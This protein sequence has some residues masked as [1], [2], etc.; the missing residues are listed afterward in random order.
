MAKNVDFLNNNS[1]ANINNNF[2]RVKTALV[3]VI[4]RSGDLP[5]QMNADLDMNS[6]DIL[7][8]DTLQV[9]DITID[10]TDPTGILERALDAVLIA[11]GSAERAELEAAEA[12][13]AAD[14]AEAAAIAAEQSALEAANSASSIQGL[15]DSRAFAISSYHPITA[16]NSIRVSGYATAGDGGGALYKKV[17]SEPTHVGKMPILLDDAVTTVWYEI[18]EA[19]MRPEMFGVLGAGAAADTTIFRNAFAVALATGASEVDARSVLGTIEFTGDIFNGIHTLPITFRTGKLVI[20]MDFNGKN[21]KI[22]SFC[23]W[24]S[25]ET[26]IE[27]TVTLDSIGGQN[28][29]ACALIETFWDGVG[30]TGGGSTNQYTVSDATGIHVGTRLAILGAWRDFQFNFTIGSAI[31]SSTVN[32]PITGP[33]STVADTITPGLI[34]MRLDTAGNIEYVRGLL[35]AG[36][37]DT[38]V[39]GGGRGQLGSTAISHSSGVA[40]LLMQSDVHVVTAI[41]GNVLTLAANL[42][43]AHTNSQ[44]RFGTVDSKLIGD[45]EIDGMYDRAVPPTNVWSCLGSTLS[46]RFEAVGDIR[47]LRAPT[48]GYFMLGT[49]D[50]HLDIS[51]IEKCGRPLTG[52]GG[53]GWLYGY[54]FGSNVHVKT[55]R[56]GYIASVID[57]K[58]SGIIFLGLDRPNEDFYVNY[59]YV[60]THSIGVDVTASFNGY[61]RIGYSDCSDS[62][63]GIFDGTPQQPGPITPTGVTID[64]A[65]NK[66]YKPATGNALAGNMVLMT[67]QGSSTAAPTASSGTIT[68]ATCTLNW[69]REGKFVDIIASGLITTVGSGAGTLN[70]PLPAGIVPLRNVAIS[71]RF[72]GVTVGT[73]VGTTVAGSSTIG[74]TKA[75]GST[76]IVAGQ[77]FIVTTRF[78][79]TN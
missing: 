52:L 50:V 31:T 16:P 22:P 29:P 33:G 49:K 24:E 27:P 18:E 66:V 20:R 35:T 9:N 57:N 47:L 53:S 19:I 58:S 37:L 3:D 56:D 34:T 75:D 54:N 63:A 64:I 5:N 62:H 61:A 72:G 41:A 30:R 2:A 4:G 69:T 39:V 70:I 76:I 51:L 67:G 17:V 44:F 28:S 59:D 14:I 1:V 60:H 79:L 15:L 6:H 13:A 25:S 68:T 45:I 42:D 32:I 11:E 55:A 71:G 7:N 43:I 74:V 48:G 12:I 65:A 38:S 77:S 73:L 40:A 21:F 26:R 46:N 10:G 36:V 8:I 23:T 78:E